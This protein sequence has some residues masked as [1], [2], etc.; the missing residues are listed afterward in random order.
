MGAAALP[1]TVA[2]PPGWAVLAVVT[3]AWFAATRDRSDSVPATGTDTQTKKCDRPWTAHVHAQGEDCGGSSASTIGAPTLVKTAAPV[4]RAEGIALSGA[5]WAMLNKNQQKIRVKAKEQLERYL[6]N[7]PPL[8]QRSF[9]ASDRKGGKRLDLDNY[10]CS[11][12]FI[13]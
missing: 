3:V 6:Q 7:R 10:G 11:P 8:G 9:P 4:T 1:L 5:T 12:N 13:G 2:G